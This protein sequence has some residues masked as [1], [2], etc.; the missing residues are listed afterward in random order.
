MTGSSPS[1]RA[2]NGARRWRGIAAA[3]GIALGPAFVYSVSRAEPVLRR[4]PDDAA[5]L[6]E[7]ERLDKTL[8]AVRGELLRLK[9]DAGNSIGS[10]LGKIFDA[11]VM[12]VEDAAIVK[13]VKGLIAQE[14][15]GAENAFSDV[16]GRAQ[17]SV[18]SATDPYLREMANDIESVK[19]RVINHLHGIA[20]TLHKQL[21]HPAI[22][23]AS[24]ITPSDIVSLRRE[25]VL[26]I[27][28]ETGGQTSHTALLAKSLNI[29]AVV[30]VGFDVRRIRPGVVV[31]VDGYDGVILLDPDPLTVE[32]IERKKKRTRS[33]WP[34]RFDVLRDLPAVTT[35]R[36][37][38]RLYANID[39]AGEAKTVVQAGSD[40]VGLYRTEYLFFERGDFPTEREQAAVYRQA[41]ETLAGRP[42]IVRTFDLGSDKAMP[43]IP[44]EQNPALG[45]RGLRLSLKH[46]QAL[47]RQMR[48]L[49]AASAH[50]PVWVMLPMVTGPDDLIAA[51][52]HWTEAKSALRKRGVPF[53][54]ATPLGA[55]IETPSAV[56]LVNDLAAEADFFS[57]G[58]NDLIQYT[59]AADRG[60]RQVSHPDDKWH[61][62][63]WR[64]I[65]SVTRAA[66]R[67]RRPV[68]L[69]GDLATEVRAIPFLVGIGLE[70]ISCHPNL[71]PRIKAI[72]RSLRYTDCRKAAE[73]LLGA[74][75]VTE[76]MSI[77]EAISRRV[78][79]PLR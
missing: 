70:S 50:G 38:I 13:E 52:E 25:H 42:L 37:R 53:D 39:L 16:L 74:S 72:V 28:T 32:F 66:R 20:E 43:G 26:G 46:P 14:R 75:G 31:A 76:A 29:P 27:V 10:M 67:R 23:L 77:V 55:M 8:A 64:Q 36:R 3:P 2:V 40:G 61:P 35:D 65:E 17:K 79:G 56:V 49:L 47:A 57:I 5:V 33:P 9:S 34:K 30:G 62:A 51:K 22:V 18:A 24:T 48:A 15:I 73:R 68:G 21:Q 4:L 19:T 54:R 41:V 6:D 44:A 7:Q 69:C 11:Q 78:R 63:V 59:L 12:I 45:L 60:N 1:R 71:V 58:T